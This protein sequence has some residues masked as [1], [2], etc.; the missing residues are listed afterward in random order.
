LKHDHQRADMSLR[1][2]VILGGILTFALVLI[3]YASLK[4][5]ALQTVLSIIMSLPLMLVGMRVLGETNNGPVSAMANIIQVLFGLFWPNN[6]A[7]NLIAAGT[8]G[9]ACA[10]AEGTIQ[11]FKTAKLIGSWPKVLTYVQLAC[12]PIGAAAV[13]IMTPL[14]LTSY[15]L[16]PDGLSAPTGLKLAS[17]AML[18]A[19]GLSSLPQHALQVTIIFV[20]IGVAIAFIQNNYRGRCAC[21]IPSAAGFGVAL[22]LPGEVTMSIAAGGIAGWIWM[23]CSRRTYN[24]YS[25]TAASGLIAGEAMVG[26]IIV[27]ALSAFGIVGRPVQ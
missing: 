13:A 6:I 2:I 27:P 7:L 9:S 21:L 15:G 19:N 16:G 18:L 11:D 24:R 3:Q 10:Q 5:P 4:A 22:I 23:R 8:T 20:V 26:G 25:I 12:V 14:L 17:M 1:T